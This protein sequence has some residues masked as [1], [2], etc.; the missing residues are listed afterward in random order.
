MAALLSVDAAS[1]RFGGLLA[2]RDVSLAIEPGEIVGLIG[3]NGAG[4]T[5]L[6]N[7]ITGYMHPDEGRIVFDGADVTRT[8][9]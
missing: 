5:T 1:K 6:F 7:C 3:P 2:N 9:P 8:R 4:K